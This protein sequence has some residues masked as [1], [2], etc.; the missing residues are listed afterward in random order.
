MCIRPLHNRLKAIQKLKPPTIVKGC[1]SFAGK[2]SFLSI[3]CLDLQK[4]LKPIY[5]LTRKER[6][7]VWGQE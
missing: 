4:P 5:D 6:Q 7:F 1:R 2:V 3:F